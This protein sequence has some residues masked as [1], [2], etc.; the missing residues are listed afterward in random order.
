MP[1]P[2]DVLTRTLVLTMKPTRRRTVPHQ[3]WAAVVPF[4]ATGVA[5]AQ[6]TYMRAAATKQL[7]ASP[8][9]T[10]EQVYDP[11]NGMFSDPVDVLDFDFDMDGNNSGIH[12]YGSTTGDFG[13]RSSGTRVYA[14]TGDYL[15]RQTFT[16]PFTTAQNVAF[17]FYINPGTIQ[18]YAPG[19]LT[20]SEFV[21]AGIAFNIRRDGTSVFSSDATL[22]TNASGTTYV[23]NGENLYTPQPAP[24][25]APST[26]YNINGGARTV[27]LGM[28]DGLA[29]LTLEYT[30]S[31]FASGN[32]P[33]R[34]FFV[35]AQTFV[36]PDHYIEFCCGGGYGYGGYGCNLAAALVSNEFGGAA[37]AANDCAQFVPGTTVTIEE[38]FVDGAPGSSHASSGDPFTFDV[39]GRVIG[40]GNNSADPVGTSFVT[41]AA[42][43][44]EPATIGLT[45]S[46]LAIIGFA[47]R[48][49]R[50]VKVT[51]G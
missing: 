34:T 39:D 32:L 3:I 10:F 36:V 15:I 1:P 2:L 8:A 6:V 45:M 44:P 30:L 24:A 47:A 17:N 37:V 46:G 9:Q 7:G 40:D 51:F 26:T 38:H 13:S 41:S 27:S 16:N 43:V 12:T 18:N 33:G 4:A 20:G 14:I 31:T 19:V 23:Q 42:T 25:G 50:R 49:R 48:R 28:L 5:H 29:S 21:T 35:P 11:A 22:T